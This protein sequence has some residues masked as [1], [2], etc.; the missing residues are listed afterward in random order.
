[1]TETYYSGAY[2]GQRT[3]NLLEWS[4]KTY[5]F[6]SCLAD[7]D[8]LFMKWFRKAESF[9]AA[10][11]EVAINISS[12]QNVIMQKTA[13][14]TGEGITLGL[15]TYLGEDQSTSASLTLNIGHQQNS[16]VLGLPNPNKS[17]YADDLL[18]YSKMYKLFLC[19]V[20]IW[21]PETALL[22]SRQ[23]RD[24]L[25]ETY[26]DNLPKVGWL[27]LLKA[28]DEIFPE[29]SPPVEVK[30]LDKHR[31]IVVGMRERLTVGNSNHM[32]T[33]NSILLVL[34]EQGLLQKLV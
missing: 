16:V 31:R 32:T 3:G 2:W 28:E 18:S 30:K 14:T 27:T 34:R 4:Q 24:S 33:M 8:A 1:M 15:W 23:Y 12:I 26:E 11:Q 9:E 17:K 10:H 13:K 5:E 6:L 25:Y 21:N 29:F 20:S 19:L 7:I 22:T